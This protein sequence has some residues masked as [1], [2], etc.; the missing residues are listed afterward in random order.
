MDNQLKRKKSI[1][2]KLSVVENQIN[3]KNIVLVDDSIV[4][5][6]TMKHIIDL[7]YKNNVKSIIVVSCAPMIKYQNYYGLDIPTKEELIANKKNTEEIKDILNVKK[8]IYLSIDEVCK[9]IT[10]LNSNLTE[11]E[12]SVFN[13]N[14]IQ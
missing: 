10:D 2:R 13:G 9:S 3:N 4:R 12:L 7:L 5:G 11:F 6:N 1:K 8:L 14:Y